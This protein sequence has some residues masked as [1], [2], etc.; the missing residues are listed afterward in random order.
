MKDE[1]SVAD[2]LNLVGKFQEAQREWTANCLS[3][4]DSLKS[5]DV[6]TSYQSLAE[7][8]AE[9]IRAALRVDVEHWD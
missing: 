3:R 7:L 8:R 6:H 4:E 5:E 1:M 2:F 9:V